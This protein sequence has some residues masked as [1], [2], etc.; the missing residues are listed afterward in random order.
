MFISRASASA[1]SNKSL[2][3]LNDT[4][5][6]FRGERHRVNHE[7]RAVVVPEIGDLNRPP[8]QSSPANNPFRFVDTSTA[9]TGRVSHHQFGL[10]GR[11]TVLADMR[12]VPLDP[13]EFHAP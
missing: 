10:V 1:R 9:G 2:S 12:G 7:E 6:L 13:A 3:M 8:A 4:P 5:F 11:Y